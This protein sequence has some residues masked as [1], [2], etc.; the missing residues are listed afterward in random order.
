MNVLLFRLC[1]SS[2]A[3]RQPKQTRVAV[4]GFRCRRQDLGDAARTR[5]LLINLRQQQPTRADVDGDNGGGGA[6]ASGDR[7][8]AKRCA[9]QVLC[10]RELLTLRRRRR[11][12]RQ[13]CVRIGAD[14]LAAHTVRAKQLAQAR[15]CRSQSGA[16]RTRQAKRPR[17][18][19]F[20][21][22]R[23]RCGQ[24]AAIGAPTVCS[25]KAANWRRH[26]SPP[27]EI[28]HANREDYATR[29]RAKQLACI[30][31]QLCLFNGRCSRFSTLWSIDA[32]RLTGANTLH[33]E[34]ATVT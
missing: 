32:L 2:A 28:R 6:A 30:C 21:A 11:R 27:R 9:Q 7:N 8:G 12:C 10:V 16:S 22:A 14:R 18:G 19:R 1:D 29:E 31:A 3:R 26:R 5:E 17:A 13:V 34:S 25:P 4:A 20:K 33:A 24:T 23:K 15:A